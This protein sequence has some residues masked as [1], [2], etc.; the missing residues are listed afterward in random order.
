MTQTTKQEIARTAAEA[1]NHPLS[2]GRGEDLE[3]EWEFLEQCASILRRRQSKV[4][5]EICEVEAM[6]EVAAD[7]RLVRGIY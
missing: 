5:D 4:E 3:W 2:I 1:M 6:R 7:R